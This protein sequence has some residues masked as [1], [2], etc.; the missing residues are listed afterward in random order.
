MEKHRIINESKSV[1]QEVGCQRHEEAT[2]EIRD[3]L[4]KQHHTVG[5]A[6]RQS[7]GQQ[8][9]RPTRDLAAARREG[10]RKTRNSRLVEKWLLTSTAGN[11]QEAKEA[12]GAQE[13]GCHWPRAFSRSKQ[14][15]CFMWDTR[16]WVPMDTS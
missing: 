16:S 14:V 6:D 4:L 12:S 9:H 10:R 7:A 5:H 3:R 8:I 13:G 2:G 11:A 1:R 15:N